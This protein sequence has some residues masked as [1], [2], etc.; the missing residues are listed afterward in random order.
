MGCYGCTRPNAECRMLETATFN[1]ATCVWDVTGV[2][3]PMPSVEC[4]KQQLLIMQLCIG[5]YGNTRPNAQPLECWETAT[6]NNATCLWDVTGTQDP[7]P[8]VECWETATFNNATCVWGML[9][10]HKTRCQV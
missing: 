4:W 2:Q 1:N 6:F 8:S 7:I 3:D 9:R 5:C 10:V